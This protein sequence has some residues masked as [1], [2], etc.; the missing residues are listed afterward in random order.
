M[1]NDLLDLRMT[2][3][4]RIISIYITYILI[5]LDSHTLMAVI[6]VEHI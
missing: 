2:I 4:H 5:C 3:Y 6:G 1:Q